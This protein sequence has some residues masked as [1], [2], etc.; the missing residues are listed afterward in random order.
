MGSAAAAA[1]TGGCR[2]ILAE[3]YLSRIFSSVEKML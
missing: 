3:K 2:E 1:V